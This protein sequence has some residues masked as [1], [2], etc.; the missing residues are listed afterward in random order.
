MIKY[1]CMCERLKLYEVIGIKDKLVF[2]VFF[3]KNVG[4]I[5]YKFC[6]DFLSYVFIFW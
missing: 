4:Y 6:V 3:K 1:E 2:N 5:I